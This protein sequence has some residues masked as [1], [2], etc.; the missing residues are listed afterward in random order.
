MLLAEKPSAEA[1]WDRLLYDALMIERQ[2]EPV[3]DRTLPPLYAKGSLIE[4]RIRAALWTDAELTG[5]FEDEATIS[6]GPLGLAPRVDLLW[7]E[8]KIVVELDGPEHG[9]EPNYG[10][11]DIGI[12]S[13]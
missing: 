3:L 9:R 12:M 8:G 1:P 4:R 7:R 2:T 6:P 5:L 10:R 11:T 13:F